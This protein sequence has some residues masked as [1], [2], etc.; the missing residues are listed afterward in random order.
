MKL[1]TLADYLKYH[2]RS[3]PEA[4]LP[5]GGISDEAFQKAGLQRTL[6]CYGCE[7]ETV[8]C[9]PEM[10]VLLEYGRPWTLKPLCDGCAEDWPVNGPYG[11]HED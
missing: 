9:T 8:P 10:T 11:E 6:L 4:D 3:F 5:G 2:G 7:E 1:R